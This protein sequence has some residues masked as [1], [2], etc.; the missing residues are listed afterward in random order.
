MN[1]QVGME[2]H[3]ISDIVFSFKWREVADLKTSASFCMKPDHDTALHARQVRS[4]SYDSEANLALL[5]HYQFA[6]DKSNI[7]CIATMLIKAQ[8]QLP[9]HDFMQMLQ[10]IPERLQVAFTAASVPAAHASRAVCYRLHACASGLQCRQ[11]CS[12]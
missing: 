4:G 2:K 3:Q 6:P 1:E 5:R 10:L 9:S 8:M 12:L 7:N 11:H